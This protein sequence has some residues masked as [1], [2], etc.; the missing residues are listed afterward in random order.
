MKLS[1]PKMKAER[2]LGKGQLNQQVTAPE[3]CQSKK[4]KIIY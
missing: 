2:H 4:V 3:T 1:D